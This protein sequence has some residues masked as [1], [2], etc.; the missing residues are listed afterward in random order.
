MASRIMG[1]HGQGALKGR[2]QKCFNLLP[3]NEGYA[4]LKRLVLRE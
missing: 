4:E 3:E 2:A 1:N